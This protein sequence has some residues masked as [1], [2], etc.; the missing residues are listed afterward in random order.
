MS[1]VDFGQRDHDGATATRDKMHSIP[2]HLV[3]MSHEVSG[4][5]VGKATRPD[6]N[7]PFRGCASLVGRGGR[8]GKNGRHDRYR[9]CGGTEG[10]CSC[11]VGSRL[12]YFTT[13]FFAGV[14]APLV[15]SNK[16]EI[17]ASFI[18]PSRPHA[19]L[20]LKNLV[21]AGRRWK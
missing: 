21:A 18:A 7:L 6:P 19:A 8:H 15:A 2:G 3:L 17:L 5:L 9:V 4:A 16:K 10:C 1:I 13:F 12:S 14:N 20:H 11:R